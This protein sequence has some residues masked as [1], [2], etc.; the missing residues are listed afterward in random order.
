MT[1]CK[2]NFAE[3]DTSI[4]GIVKFGDNSTVAINGRGTV[5]IEGRTGQH[6]AITDVYYISKLTSNIISLGQLKE[7]DCRVVLEDGYLKVYDH[8]EQLLIRV[9]ISF[10]DMA[11][12]NIIF[13]PP[14]LILLLLLFCEVDHQIQNTEYVILAVTLLERYRF[15]RL[16]FPR[17]FRALAP[18]Y[19]KI[20]SL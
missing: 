12:E 6:K 9:V 7:R 1:G 14:L 15:G 5:L 2:E 16:N 4:G 13:K 18:T 8:K 20:L 3:L 17:V 11:T 10:G 19:S